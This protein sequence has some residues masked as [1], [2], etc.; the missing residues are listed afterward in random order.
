M[1]C[2]IA[3]LARPGLAHPGHPV[4][5]RGEVIRAYEN[6]VQERGDIAIAEGARPAWN[7]AIRLLF[8]LI[9]QGTT[10]ICIDAI[11]ECDEDLRGDFLDL[12]DRLLTRV[13]GGRVKILISSR[14]WLKIL[15]RF[16][17]WP[18]NDIDVGKNCADLRAYARHRAAE[19]VKR[20]R[21]RAHSV[22]DNWEETTIQQLVEDSQG[23]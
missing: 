3:Q 13:E 19:C 22:P 1:C 10:T 4:P 21:Q 17:S 12:I 16:P 14:P 2:L 9:D 23:M 18:S 15:D 20:M 7:D 6:M 11:D 5:L 8:G